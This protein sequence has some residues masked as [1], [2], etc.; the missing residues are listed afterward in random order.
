MLCPIRMT[1]PVPMSAMGP[2]RVWVSNAVPS[3]SSPL[4]KRLALTPCTLQQDTRQQ[5]RYLAGKHSTRR[6]VIEGRWLRDMHLGFG[7]SKVSKYLT[8]FF[9]GFFCP[10]H[11]NQGPE[12]RHSQCSWSNWGQVPCLR[13]QWQNHYRGTAANLWSELDTIFPFW[14]T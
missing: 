11:P 10:T 3:S 13:V 14:T 12:I 1:A 6:W 5:S 9:S 8:F 2:S 7:L 4:K